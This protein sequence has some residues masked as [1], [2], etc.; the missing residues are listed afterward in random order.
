[1]KTTNK[2]ASS[3]SSSSSSKGGAQPSDAHTAESI[4]ARIEA[5]EKALPVHL[6]PY[7]GSPTPALPASVQSA[8]RAVLAKACHTTKWKWVPSNYYDTPLDARATT[9]ACDKRSL[10][11]AML[12]ENVKHSGASSPAN[13]QFY[14]VLV[15]YVSAIDTPKL[16]A[17]VRTLLPP[18]ERLG[19]KCFEFK[20]AKESDSDRLT[21]FT[22]NSVSPFG[23][24]TDVPIIFPQ[25]V[26]DSCN[27]IYMGGGHV[28]L[29]IGMSVREFVEVTKCFV[30]DVTK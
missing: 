26:A 14:L 22:H 6:T 9:L 1:M 19:S 10:T 25:A 15:Q 28:D 20:L 11:K 29:K 24:Q 18:K 2:Q 12:M 7:S 4:L 23:L 30:G 5:L 17:F 8:F 21:G 16:E 3:L 13:S 27:Y